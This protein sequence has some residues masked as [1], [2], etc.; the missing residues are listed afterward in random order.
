MGG[1]GVEGEQRGGSNLF[2]FWVYLPFCLCLWVSLFISGFS[3]WFGLCF[4]LSG[5]FF[6]VLSLRV[7]PGS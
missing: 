4:F 3:V 6:W 7:C 1:G 2:P 5:L